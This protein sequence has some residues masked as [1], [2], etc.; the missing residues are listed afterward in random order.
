[1]NG[2]IYSETPLFP[3]LHDVHSQ[4]GE[5]GIVEEILIRL[6]GSSELK[7]EEFANTCVEFGA[8]D[9]IHLSN[10]FN[11]VE[12][13][14]WNAIY[15]EGDELKFRDLLKT[16]TQHPRITPYCGYVSAESE[17]RYSLDN[18]LKE[19]GCPKEFQL[20]SIDIDSYDLEIWE[21]LVEFAPDIV[22]I[23]INSTFPPGIELRQC[24]PKGGSTFSATLKV[25]HAKGYELV[26]H[27]GNLFFVKRELIQR[28]N[29]PERYLMYPELLFRTDWLNKSAHEISSKKMVKELIQRV[30]KTRLS[31]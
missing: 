17:S 10:T 16:C 23:E 13:K 29:L 28:I 11:L 18:I 4:N 7:G 8:W 20:L 24:S 3:F 6:Y 5:D 19:T 14:G 30:V 21:S 31:R 22:I 26:C 12:N 1:M 25:A 9:G 27:T 15:I 2:N